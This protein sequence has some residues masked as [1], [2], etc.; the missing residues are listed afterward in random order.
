MNVFTALPQFFRLFQQGQEIANAATWKNATVATNVLVGALGT[1]V[2]IAASAGIGIPVDS[3]TLQMVGS[4]IVAAISA[5][6][7]VMHV[8][9]SSRVGF[10]SKA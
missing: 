4:G 7:A 1:A 5:I 8:I 3:G 2:G 9:T 10:A 6:N